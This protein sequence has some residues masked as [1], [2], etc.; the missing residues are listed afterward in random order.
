MLLE[1]VYTK[2]CLKAMTYLSLDIRSFLKELSHKKNVCVLREE[3]KILLLPRR[4]LKKCLVLF[5]RN[6][7]T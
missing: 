1:A 7:I 5:W 6:I 4:L 3:L 2:H